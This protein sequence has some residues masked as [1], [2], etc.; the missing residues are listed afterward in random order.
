MPAIA[1]VVD[2]LEDVAEPVRQFYV[3]KDGKFSLDLSAAPVGFVP[4]ADFAAANG[5]VVEFRDTNIA[6]K[7][8]VDELTPKVKAFEGIDA[9]AARAALDA[10]KLLKD[11]GVTKPDDLQNIVNAAVT[12]ALKPVQEQLVTI[13]STNAE[14]QK[15]AD[16]LTLRSTLSDV[17]TKAGGQ[18]T[19][20]DFVISRAQ[21]VFKVDGGKVVPEANQFSADKPGEPLSVDEWLTRQTKEIPFAFKA[22]SGGGASPAG[23]PIPGAGTLKPGQTVLTDPTPQQLGAAAKDIR[24]G[25]VRVVYSETAHQ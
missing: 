21:G 12:A 1:P 25:K 8:Q 16:G 17:F 13:T 15:R 11:K 4:A 23:G 22:S 3:P 10:Q 5:K 2:K 19:A 24:D 9:E 7:K 14:N 20:L 18:A 6:L